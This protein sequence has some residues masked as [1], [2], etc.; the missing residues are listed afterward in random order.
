MTDPHGVASRLAAVEERISDAC[1][2]AGRPRGGVTLIGASKVHP[3]EVLAAAYDAG[4]R[5]FGENRVQE[6]LEKAPQLPDDIDWHLIGPLQSNKVR[7][8]VTL[9]STIHSI[10]RLKIARAIDRV[11]AESGARRTGLIE[12]NVGGEASK[13][14]FDPG[15]LARDLEELVRLEAL[16]IAGLMTIPPFGGTAEASRPWFERLRTLAEEIG[17]LGLPGWRGWLSMGMSHDLEVAIECGATHVRV[18]TDL[19]GPR[20]PRGAPR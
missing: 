9:F 17:G 11:A 3:P 4:L 10:D 2:E 16:D 20:P 1:L 19:F 7:K 14:G 18:G 6:G 15:T 5:T 12:V 13:H 8:A